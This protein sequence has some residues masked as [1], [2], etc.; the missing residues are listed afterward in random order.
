MIKLLVRKFIKNHEDVKDSKVREKYGVLGGVL[1]IICNLLL[2][3]IKF[4]IG[5][6]V[7]AVAVM[8]DAFN[9]LTDS[10]SSIVGIISAK[11]SNKKPDKDHPFGHGRIEYV[12]TLIVAFII[13][14]VGFEL[15]MTSGEKLLVGLGL[16]EGEIE[17]IA[18]GMTLYISLGILAVSLLVKLWMYSYNKYL[19]KK[20]NSSVMLAN[21]ADS[22]S[23]VLTSS[24]II[25]ATLLGA[26]LLK[27]NYFYLD[28]AMGIIV[29]IIICINGFKIVLETIG[30]LLGRPADKEQLEELEAVIMSSD[31]ILGI[32]DL[33]IHDYGPGR[34]FASVHAEVDSKSDVIEAH[35]II[36]EIEQICYGKTGIELVIHMDPIDTTSPTVLKAKEVIGKVIEEY[37][38][39]SYH[40]LRITDGEHNINVIFDL[41]VPHQYENDKLKE[42]VSTIKSKVKEQNNKYTLVIKVDRP[43]VE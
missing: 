31:K 16:I 12:S 3:G 32:H 36:D 29:S 20:V 6:L 19:G 22:I 25:I 38:G 21:S 14:L 30:D 42:L 43:Y 5:V 41:V 1:G 9:N 27:E 17:T 35:E 10:F 18:S 4:A 26:L 8:S 34:K 39:V 37:E 33:I 24:A 40:D 15:L 2:F 13:L 7:N 11:I 23:D 28:A